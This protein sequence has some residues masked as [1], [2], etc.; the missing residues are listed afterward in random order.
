M[1]PFQSFEVTVPGSS[2]NMG[3]GFDSIGLAINRYLRIRFSPAEETKVIVKGD[4]LQRLLRE[5]KNLIIDVMRDVFQ[6]MDRPMPSFQMEVETEIPLMR[7][8][9][10]SAAAIVAGLIAANHLLGNPF[11]REA[12]FQEAVHWEGHPDNVGPAL[13]GGLV[14]AAWDGNKAHAI[15]APIPPFSVVAAIPGKPL[16]TSK[17]R[18]VLPSQLSHQEAVLGSSRANLL[19]ASLFT[20]DWEAFRVGLMDC[21][22]QP[23][24]SLLIPGLDQ[25]LQGAVKHGAL[26]AALSGAGPTVVAFALDPEPVHHF[27][28]ETFQKE[29]M[30]MDILRLRPCERGATVR[31]TGKEDRSRVFEK[32]KGAG[33]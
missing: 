24:R 31:L 13:F 5:K 1:K 15:Q 2:A 23:Y 29:G 11:D 27:M 32:I 7:G 30:L 17:A 14:V 8:L 25:V 20:G 3:S 4:E 6:K 16:A 18:E 9:G 19:T 26:G 21:F 10:S 33:R 22:H 12:L 28:E